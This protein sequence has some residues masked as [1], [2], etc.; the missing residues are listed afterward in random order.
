M[1]AQ[2]VRDIAAEA[3]ADAIDI[4]SIIETLE[5]GLQTDHGRVHR[6]FRELLAE[7]ALN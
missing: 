1:T 5:A 6:K 3:F 2:M 7:Q 4:C